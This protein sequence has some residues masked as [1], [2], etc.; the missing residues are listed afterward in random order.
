MHDED[1]GCQRAHRD[2]RGAVR[3][4]STHAAIGPQALGELCIGVENTGLTS[5]AR[6]QTPLGLPTRNADSRSEG[7]EHQVKLGEFLSPDA[8]QWTEFAPKRR[9]NPHTLNRHPLGPHEKVVEEGRTH[10]RRARSSGM[11]G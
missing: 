10:G 6:A 7:A 2:G 3:A 4:S 9:V 8:C 1:C 11:P 5:E